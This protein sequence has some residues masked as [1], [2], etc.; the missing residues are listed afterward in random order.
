M[1]RAESE[2]ERRSGEE[3]KA[4]RGRIPCPAGCRFRNGGKR[5]SGAALGLLI[6]SGKYRQTRRR[7]GSADGRRFR[8]VKPGAI[9]GMA[10]LFAGVRGRHR[11]WQKVGGS[12]F[13][14]AYFY[15]VIY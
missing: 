6:G 12:G 14:S 1:R 10:W 8:I 4:G 7:N 5:E 13:A 9:I 15:S 3:E 2:N 11:R